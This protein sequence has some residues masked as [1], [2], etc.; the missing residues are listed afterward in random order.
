MPNRKSSS[1][2]KPNAKRIRDLPERRGSSDKPAAPDGKVTGGTKR[3][4]PDPLPIPYP[5]R[6]LT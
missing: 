5:G 6:G 2:K 4:S 3:Q 1:S